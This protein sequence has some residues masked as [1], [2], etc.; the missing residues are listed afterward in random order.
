[1]LN[2]AIQGCSHEDVSFFS[3]FAGMLSRYA[4]ASSRATTQLGLAWLGTAHICPA[5]T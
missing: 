2:V 1:M 5:G 4:K 3:F